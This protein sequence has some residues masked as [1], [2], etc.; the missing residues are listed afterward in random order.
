M[1]NHKTI[2][3]YGANGYTGRLITELSANYG[4]KPILAGRDVVAIRRLADQYGLP[5]RA[6]SLHDTE[7]IVAHLHDCALVLNA[8][9]PFRY[10]AEPMLSACLQ[11]GVHYLDITGE[12]PVFEMAMQM[13]AK[14]VDTGIM[15][16]PGVGF[17]VVPTDCMALYL[18]RQMP[19]A[20]HLQ[21][22]F[23]SVGG[24]ISH[25]TALTL[26]E[27]LG[28]DSAVRRNGKIVPKP[29]G[30]KGM[31][32]D[33]GY[34]QRF[35]MTIPS[36]DIATAHH[37][38][39]IPNIEVYFAVKP[40]VYYLLKGQALLNPLLRT[41]WMKQMLRKRVDASIT[42]PTNEERQKARSLVW[43]CVTNA[44]GESITSSFIGPEGYTLTAHSSLL[45]ASKVL[46]NQ[47]KP[48]YQT[49]AGCY[50]PDLVLEISGTERYKPHVG[51]V[52]NK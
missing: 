47:W 7:N 14:A 22:A 3:L 43:G 27:S 38:T 35:A 17:D 23:A 36:G 42:G 21:L 8:A 52:T 9:G 26:I 1:Q 31:T 25:G 37:T 2:L 18:S 19:D 44:A 39:G 40:Y 51:H 12:I 16:M 29:L 28:E 13:H 6:F 5:W 4:I 30:H 49:P 24:G 15:M 50:G 48:G 11:A 20:T 34:K 41:K 33:F 45:I 32:V 10:T 46:Q